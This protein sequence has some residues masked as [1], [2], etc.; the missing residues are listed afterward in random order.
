MCVDIVTYMY[1]DDGSSLSGHAGEASRPRRNQKLNR[2]PK[3]SPVH[4]IHDSSCKAQWDGGLLAILGF[5]WQ[6]MG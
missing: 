6:E 3:N 4:E 1:L 5:P 2:D